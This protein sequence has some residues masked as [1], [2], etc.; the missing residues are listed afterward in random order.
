MYFVYY[1]QF[2]P[3]VRFISSNRR[4]AI[5]MRD[6]SIEGILPSA[7]GRLKIYYIRPNNELCD[8]NRL[9]FF[10]SPYC[11]AKKYTEVTWSLNSKGSLGSWNS[12]KIHWFHL[13]SRVWRLLYEPLGVCKNFQVVLFPSFCMRGVTGSLLWR[14]CSQRRQLWV[15]MAELRLSV[16]KIPKP[17]MLCHDEK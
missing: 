1:T 17:V 15:S 7:P 3:F 14:S 10:L 2:Q 8:P 13:I 6:S 4:L 9:L 5:F 12:P 16:V 11:F